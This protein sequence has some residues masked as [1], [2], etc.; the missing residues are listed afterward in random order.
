MLSP[1]G[2]MSTEMWERVLRNV[3][4]V[5]EIVSRG[6][7]LMQMQD[8]NDQYAIRHTPIESCVIHVIYKMKVNL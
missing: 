5:G 6:M 7:S 1:K 2:Q 4:T 8:N 3:D